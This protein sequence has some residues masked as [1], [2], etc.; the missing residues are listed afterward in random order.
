VS[1]VHIF[2]EINIYN[3]TTNPL[4]HQSQGIGGGA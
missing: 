3:C 2:I 4:G 1:F